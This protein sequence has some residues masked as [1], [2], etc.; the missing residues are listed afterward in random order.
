MKILFVG[1]YSNL[2]ATLAAEL[3]R[4]GHEATVVSD[5]GGY[6]HTD[7]DI[8]LQ[9]GPETLGAFRY[10]RDIFEILPQLRGYD[11]VQLINPHF[12]KLRPGK[13]RYFFSALKRQNG[14]ICLTLAG[15]DH[16]FVRACTRTN[17][18]PYSEFRI[19]STPTPFA[20]ECPERERGYM[21]PDVE[22]YDR[23]IFDSIDGAMSVL[24]EYDL[25][26]RGELGDRLTY[27]GIPIDTR[28]FQP[29]ALPQA[30][31]KIILVGTRPGM[32]TQ[33]G[34]GILAHAA[35]RIEAETGGEWR[36]VETG[37]LSLREYMDF[38][39][40][41]H[42]VLDQLYALSPATNALGAMACG[43]LAASG[44]SEEYYNF[45]G[46]HKLRPIVPVS[47]DADPFEAL[48]PVLTDPEDILRRARE[49]RELVERHND[50]RVVA[51][52][53]ID[54]WSRIMERR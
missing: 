16:I 52:R 13:L 45:I 14:A 44:G 21:R 32:A 28:L 40:R 25:A 51:S 54:A 3:R 2:H 38:V 43:R 29:S 24:Y 50:V 17:L 9:R 20:S 5:G 31:Q 7:C 1:D 10:L 48:L 12:F 11:V 15:N 27:T 26:A 36:L 42:I 33:K 41:S 46:E 47:P 37:G 6:Q 30:E 19:G 18:F 53:F 39:R 23:W 35:R 22:R 4:R 8:L 34:T 49:G